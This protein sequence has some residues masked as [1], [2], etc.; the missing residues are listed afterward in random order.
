M[1]DALRSCTITIAAEA[2]DQSEVAMLLD[3]ADARSASLYPDE[4]RHGSPIATL[5]AQDVSF[6]VVRRG[7]E[8]VGCGG[9]VADSTTDGE[10]KRIF[11]AETARRAG[12][13]RLILKTLEE[14]ARDR[15]IQL[16]RLETGIKSDEA[17]GLYRRSGYIER[18]PFGAYRADPLSIF[19]EKI[20]T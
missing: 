10:L 2:P 1:I 17:L 18:G 3:A 12:L 11:V 13:G 7:G 19:M 15:S 9:F 5:L 14:A 16:M 4:S 6:F 8:V 20:L